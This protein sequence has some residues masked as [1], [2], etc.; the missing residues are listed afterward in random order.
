MTIDVANLGHN[1]GDMTLAQQIGENLAEK[2]KD[3]KDRA[4][5]LNG[6]L[7]R[8]PKA[9]DNVT[10]ADKL[11]EA[12]RQCTAFLKVANETRIAE[13]EPFLSAGRA[14]DGFF[15]KLA[16]DVEKTKSALL[17]VRT[18]YDVAV[19][20]A[21]RM[22]REEDARRAREEAD[23]AR[24]EA[25]RIAAEARSKAA[26]ERAAEQ[27]AVAEQ[28]AEEAHQE[29]KATAA[30]LTRTRTDSGVL[31]SLKSEWVPEIIEPKKVPRKYCQPDEK[32]LRAAVK[33]AVN[34]DGECPLEIPG[35]RIYRKYA[36]QVR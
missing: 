11:S 34:A 35:V 2:H 16:S 32:L 12:V 20:R 15:Q 6:M 29:T 24:Q 21:A 13:K 33:S 18:A 22:Q 14:V 25:E 3:I 8:A 10:D 19:E 30:E 28:R 1:S 36:S 9:V 5:E 26:I 4:A 17:Q 27:A 23:R 7:E 31:T